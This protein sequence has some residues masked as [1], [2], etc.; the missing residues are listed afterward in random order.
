MYDEKFPYPHD[1]KLIELIYNKCVTKNLQTIASL[2]SSQ[3]FTWLKPL[4]AST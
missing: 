3:G 4:V 1:E 2:I